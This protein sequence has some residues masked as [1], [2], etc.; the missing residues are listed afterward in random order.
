MPDSTERPAFGQMWDYGTTRYLLVAPDPAR[1]YASAWLCLY[2]GEGHEALWRKRLREDYPL[3][4][5]LGGLP[6]GADYL[7][8]NWRRV[9]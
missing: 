2:L 5:S 8:E 7:D 1:D 3:L 6:G 4:D 9:E